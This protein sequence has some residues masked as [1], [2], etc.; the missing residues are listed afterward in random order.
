VAVT[1]KHVIVEIVGSYCVNATYILM[2]VVNVDY[3][4]MSV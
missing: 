4:L 1:E 2:I 3:G